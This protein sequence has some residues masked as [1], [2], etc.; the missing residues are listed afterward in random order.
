MLT[1]GT[2][3]QFM[4]M[5]YRIHSP[6]LAGEIVERPGRWTDNYTVLADTIVWATSYAREAVENDAMI[7]YELPFD[8]LAVIQRRSARLEEAERNR[9]RQ[10]HISQLE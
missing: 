7:H 8:R 10:L 2:R 3:V 4:V 5:D 6:I 1:V 9:E